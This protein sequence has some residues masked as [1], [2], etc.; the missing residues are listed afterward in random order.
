MKPYSNECSDNLERISLLASG[1]ASDQVSIAVERHVAECSECASRLSEM[2]LLVQG[3]Q[4]SATAEDRLDGVGMSNRVLESIRGQ[5]VSLQ[6]TKRTWTFRVGLMLATLA[7]TVMIMVGVWPSIQRPE[8][9]SMAARLEMSNDGQASSQSEWK[10]P[11]RWCDWNRALST[12]DVALEELF[13]YDAGGL[14]SSI[15]DRNALWLEMGK[16]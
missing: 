4:R 6:M 13:A 16:R 3:L 2:Q 10:K 14:A 11:P 15:T 7:A 9:P 8:E 5:S 1:C 12:S